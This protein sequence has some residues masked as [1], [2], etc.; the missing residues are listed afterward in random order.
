MR[1]RFE[2]TLTKK[3]HT[4]PTS[5]WKETQCHQSSGKYKLKLQW[6]HYTFT[7]EWLKLKRVVILNLKAFRA[8]KLLMHRWWKC[9]I[10][11]QLWETI[12]PSCKVK[13]ILSDTLISSTPRG[14]PKKKENTCKN[15]YLNVHSS[16]I[17][18]MQKL[19]IT[20]MSINM[21]ID[22]LLIIKVECNSATKMTI[23]TI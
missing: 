10:V 13:C 15:L 16:F 7:L 22:K 1:K 9:K 19:E 8:T 2:W 18:N 4:W 12:A 20:Q 3:I 6:D 23:Y 11:Q 21:W 17:H 14:L 5:I